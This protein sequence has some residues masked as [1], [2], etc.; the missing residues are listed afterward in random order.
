MTYASINH[1]DHK[2]DQ[3]QKQVIIAF[4]LVDMQLG[5]EL[6]LVKGPNPPFDFD[7]RPPLSDS[8]YS[9]D[10]SDM[11]AFEDELITIK[12]KLRNN[13]N[14]NFIKVL[15]LAQI[16]ASQLLP[17]SRSLKW[18]S[19][20]ALTGGRRGVPEGKSDKPIGQINIEA[21]FLEQSSSEILRSQETKKLQRS[22]KILDKGLF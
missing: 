3:D 11:E 5:K 16:R 8:E 12:V 6:G 17:S 18:H 19:L 14:P 22:P 20:Y 21:S 9:Q 2:P 13:Y 15:G 4:S 10:S 7:I 1:N